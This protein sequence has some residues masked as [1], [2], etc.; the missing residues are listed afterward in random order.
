GEGAAEFSI[1][2]PGATQWPQTSGGSA[3]APD[4]PFLVRRLADAPGY[5]ADDRRGGCDDGFSAGAAD[6]ARAAGGLLDDPPWSGP[7]AAARGGALSQHDGSPDEPAADHAGHGLHPGADDGG[8][9]P[10]RSDS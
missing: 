8:E 6:E 3:P 5:A 7:R 10:A 9:G 1:A 4:S 2:A